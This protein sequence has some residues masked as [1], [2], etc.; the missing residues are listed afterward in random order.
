MAHH[1]ATVARGLAD[2]GNFTVSILPSSGI[3][4]GARKGTTYLFLIKPP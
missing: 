1:S 2:V 3:A 4:A